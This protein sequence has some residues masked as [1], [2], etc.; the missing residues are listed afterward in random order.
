MTLK[1]KIFKV[2]GDNITD[3]TIKVN[4]YDSEYNHQALDFLI[5]TNTTCNIKG[6]GQRV[7][8]WADKKSKKQSMINAYSVTLKNSRGEYTYDF[9]DSVNNTE[10]GKSSRHDFYSV[11]ACMSVYYPDSFDDFV[12]EFGYEFN[13]ESEYIKTKQIHLSC[14]EEKKALH[15]LFTSEQLEKLSEIN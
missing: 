11:I 9:Y 14:L 1:E 4:G 2:S 15:R 5:E 8:S 10:K 12:S 13:N 7:P 3:N 6:I